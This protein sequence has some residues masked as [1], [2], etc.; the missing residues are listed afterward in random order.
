MQ[1]NNF[2]IT[3]KYEIKCKEFTPENKSARNVIIGV[4]GF[5]GDK[6]SSMLRKLALSVCENGGA[7]ICFDFPSHGK[8]PVG[9]DM[10]TIE[11]C[12]NDLLAVVEYVDNKYPEAK[13]SIFA[14]SFGGYISLLCAPQFDN[15][16]LVLRAPAVTMP[17][18]LLETVLK[19][20][21][22]DFERMGAVECGF[23]RRLN[24]PY[25]FSKDLWQ[26][27]SVYDIKLTLPTLIIHGDMDDIV[28]PS[29][30]MDFV[31]VQDST[32][33]EIIE[34]ADHRFKNVGE[35][36]KVIGLTKSFLNI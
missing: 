20:S 27:K 23:D 19:I 11:N 18:I 22:D 13:K 16:S 33:L 6:D 32:K 17:K 12:K 9:E 10:L 36:E 24:L 34:G 15:I 25:S 2:S 28:P 8:S 7:L 1:I 4:H 35:M 5:A 3:R 14:T 29:D 30:V 21:A 31:K 26:Q